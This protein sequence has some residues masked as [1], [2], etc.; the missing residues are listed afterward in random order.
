VKRAIPHPDFNH[1]VKSNDIMLLQVRHTFQL[2][3]PSLVQGLPLPLGPCSSLFSI[4]TN[5][6]IQAQRPLAELN[7][8]NLFPSAGEKGQADSSCAAPQAAQSHFPGEA[9]D[10]VQCGRMG[11]DDP[12]RQ[13]FRQTAGGA[14]ESDGGPSVQ[15]Q[16]Y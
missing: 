13:T 8:L 1:E 3:L 15:D 5:T 2:P 6:D 7:S 16:L 12:N 9:R 10:S 11:V 4:L 14:A